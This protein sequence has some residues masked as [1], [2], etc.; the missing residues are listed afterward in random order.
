MSPK[1]Q[2]HTLGVSTKHNITP[3]DQKLPYPFV[4]H[5]GVVPVPE[6]SS[7]FKTISGLPCRNL[8]G[9]PEASFG[10]YPSSGTS[11]IVQDSAWPFK[12]PLCAQ[13]D[14]IDIGRQA[15]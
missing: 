1:V 14:G 12:Q 11:A 8:P 6:A 15:S 2:L 9:A 4:G 5:L 10:P 13:A 3:H 7:K